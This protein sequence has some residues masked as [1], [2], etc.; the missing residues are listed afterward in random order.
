MSELVSIGK[1][2]G[3]PF[4]GPNGFGNCVTASK[5]MISVIADEIEAEIAKRFMELP[6]DADGVPIKP[7]DM[8]GSE[9][10]KRKRVWM[11]SSSAFAVYGDLSGYNPKAFTHVKP[12]TLEDVMREFTDEIIEWSGY[13]GPVKDGKT[14]SDVYTKYADE[15]RATFG[16]VD[17]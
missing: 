12:R 9:I 15:I 7:G 2:R 8:V 1:L 5:E 6:V 4:H 10:S 3:L 17:E 11:V 16:E 14:W 13:S